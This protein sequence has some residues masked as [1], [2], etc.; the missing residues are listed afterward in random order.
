MCHPLIGNILAVFGSAYL[1]LQCC[2][3]LCSSFEYAVLFLHSSFL[4]IYASALHVHSDHTVSSHFDCH[5]LLCMSQSILPPP[6]VEYQK[7]RCRVAFHALRFRE[8]VQNL[9]IKILNR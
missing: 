3:T 2:L 1:L 6:L 4:M 7:L 9:A 8:E 5:V